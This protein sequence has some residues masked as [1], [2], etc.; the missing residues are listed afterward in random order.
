MNKEL[1]DMLRK[2]AFFIGLLI[3][4]QPSLLLAQ[5][6]TDRNGFAQL[7]ANGTSEDV[8]LALEAG[9]DAN[10]PDDSHGRTPLMNALL[11]KDK[12]VALQKIK[13][14]MAAKADPKVLSKVGQTALFYAAAMQNIEAI[15]LLLAA[16]AD[17]H[18]NVFDY[19]IS[20]TPMMNAL[21][22]R[23]FAAALEVVKILLAAKADP[24]IEGEYGDTALHV[25]A[26]IGNI[27]AVKLLLAAGANINDTDKI[28]KTPLFEACITKSDW[29][30]G[31]QANLLKVLL[32]AGADV[33]LRPV[34]S[35]PL[36]VAAYTAEPESLKLLLEAG[37]EVNAA[38]RVGTTALMRAAN[39]NPNPDTVR[40][41]LGYGADPALRDYKGRTALDFAE[42][43]DTPAAHAIKELIM[44]S[45]VK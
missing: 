34:R 44:E 18:V 36:I 3:I 40:L 39:G 24:N 42:K 19:S 31:W 15:N 22:T 13:I 26:G 21:Q 20:T 16:G 4:C 5:V 38:N 17:V 14:L 37:C 29:P 35:A 27:E 10:A 8:R 23:D 41:L 32:E 30:P 7:C 2:T 28:G 33:Q 1:P 9:A 43:N 25:A 45:Q 11:D 6:A 12:A